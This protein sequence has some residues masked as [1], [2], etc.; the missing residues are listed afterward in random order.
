M[1]K[2][3]EVGSGLLQDAI[4]LLAHFALPNTHQSSAEERH[5]L[6]APRPQHRILLT[7]PK[8][9]IALVV[10]LLQWLPMLGESVSDRSSPRVRGHRGAACPRDRSSRANALDYKSMDQ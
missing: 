2:D 3:F 8:N 10:A 7:Q 6:L 9:H 1:V 5:L 4:L